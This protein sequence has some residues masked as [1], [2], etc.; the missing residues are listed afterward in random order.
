M[1]IFKE[2][3]SKPQFS[4]LSSLITG[5]LHGY[6][7][8]RKIAD[9]F[10]D[11]DQSSLSRFMLSDA[12]DHEEIN[13]H[14]ISYAKEIADQKYKEYYSLIIDDGVTMKYGK[15][16]PGIGFYFSHTEG[17]IVW[18]QTILTSHLICGDLDIPLY[19]DVYLK[20]NQISHETP[21]FRSKIKIAEDHIAK[22]PK[23]TG[24]KGVVI[25]DSWF[26]SKGLIQKTIESGFIGLF[27]IKSNRTLEENN[28]FIQVRDICK[29]AKFSPV[30]AKNNHFRCIT[31]KTKLKT[32]NIPVKLLISQKYDPKKKKWGSNHYIVSTDVEMRAFTMLYLYLE[33]WKIETF[34][35]FSKEELGF[36]INRNN[37]YLSFLRFIYVIFHSFT[38]LALRN[39]NLSVLFENAKSNYHSKNLFVKANMWLLILWSINKAAEGF[40]L[41]EIRQKLAL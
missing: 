28:Q 17:R 37:S 15:Q 12:W 18:G 7:E 14:R 32:G 29:N 13:N 8:I 23:I 19:A 30:K 6:G 11:K 16:L 2:L 22:F 3:L 24:K 25:A 35:K 9:F 26:S 33:R 31:M 10:S 40:S 5:N 39:C 4:H 27:G 38:Y 41:I 34:Y 36:K 20:E 21:E 1:N